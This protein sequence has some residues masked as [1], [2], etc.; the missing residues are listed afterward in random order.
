[1]AR[2]QD[3]PIGEMPDIDEVIKGLE[4]CKS[5]YGSECK[6]CPYHYRD[7]DDCIEALAEDALVLLKEQQ[8]IKE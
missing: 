8:R 7:G 3:H 1:M 2:L 5:I 6:L 4:C